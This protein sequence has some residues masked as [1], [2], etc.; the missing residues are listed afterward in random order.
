MEM[1]Y[2]KKIPWG[3]KCYFIA[4]FY[5]SGS[6][7]HH[8]LLQLFGDLAAHFLFPSEE[9]NKCSI[10]SSSW[11]RKTT[12]HKFWKLIL[13]HILLDQGKIASQKFVA[14]WKREQLTAR[15]RFWPARQKVQLL[16]K[17]PRSMG[18]THRFFLHLP[19]FR[20]VS[21]SKVLVV[22]S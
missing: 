12:S 19:H 20:S 21:I 16:L 11:R 4:I 15:A 3:E 7:K 2:L 14:L 22:P 10:N 5:Y 1:L 13:N 18:G 17:R 6:S 9:Q 8:P